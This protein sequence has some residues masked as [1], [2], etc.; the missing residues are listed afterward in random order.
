[1]RRA[2]A[3][4]AVCSL[5]LLACGDDDVSVG[6]EGPTTTVNTAP[7]S[8]QGLLDVARERWQAAGIEDYT[9][10]YERFCFCPPFAVTV[11]VVDSVGVSHELDPASTEEVEILTMEDLFDEVQSALDTAFE[12]T[13]EYDD[14]TGQVI[15]LDVDQIE[16][17]IDDEYSFSV[18]SLTVAGETP[19]ATQPPIT[20]RV[21]LS[22]SFGCAYGFH[23]SNPEQTVGLRVDFSGTPTTFPA[24]IELPDPSWEAVVVLGEELYANWCNDV[25][26]MSQPQPRI[27][28]TWTIVGGTIEFV[29]DP[30]EVDPAGTGPVTARLVGLVAERP[31]GSRVPL[32][33]LEVTNDS[34]GMFAG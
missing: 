29:G 8:E 11:E 1:M 32:R 28:E 14:Q 15:T 9:W 25:I 19:P 34:W 7:A 22:E 2:L 12:V 6:T 31:D 24:V 17:A 27:D 10:S 26:D 4:L 21:E 20:D 18:S 33:D 16:N 3:L 13:V 5:T 23:A 30:P